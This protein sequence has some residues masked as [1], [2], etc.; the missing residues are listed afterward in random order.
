MGEPSS[1]V[2]RRD[3]ADLRAFVPCQKQCPTVVQLHLVLPPHRT[4]LSAMA[5]AAPGVYL[6]DSSS[7]NSGVEL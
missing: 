1:H 3:R 2:G 7:T 6:W 5:M 4:L